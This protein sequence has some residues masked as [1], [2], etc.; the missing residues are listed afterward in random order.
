MNI[1]RILKYQ[2]EVG[3][4][5]VARPVAAVPSVMAHGFDRMTFERPV[6]DI[7]DMNILFDDDIAGEHAVLQPVAQAT[8]RPGEIRK[9]GI[10]GGAIVV[11]RTGNDVSERAGVD[12]PHQLDIW[13]RHTNLET[14]IQAEFPLGFL[15]DL[16]HAFGAGNVDGHRFFAINMLARGHRGRQVLDME[17]RRRR[18]HDGVHQLRFHDLLVRFWPDE[19]LLDAAVP[20]GRGQFVDLLLGFVQPVLKH[21]GH[22]DQARIRVVQNRLSVGGTAASTSQQ[23]HA[24]RRVCLH[25][26][27][28]LR[29]Q[30]RECSGAGRGL[31]KSAPADVFVTHCH[32]SFSP[33]TF[34]EMPSQPGC[35]WPAPRLRSRARW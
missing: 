12:A 11:D 29:F 19:R 30:N 32:V 35:P 20:F 28:Q 4:T 24:H 17:I 8:Q 16:E 21:V 15:A 5:G 1:V 26:T 34:Q 25:A 6:A 14:N 27:H 33:S 13:G 2:V 31:E 18:D 10:Y 7:N 23:S 9:I 22:R 3:G